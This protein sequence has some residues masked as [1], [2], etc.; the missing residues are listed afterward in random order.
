MRRVG[1]GVK[2]NGK[3]GDTEEGK[4]GGKGRQKCMRDQCFLDFDLKNI[5][6]NF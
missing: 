6:F 5:F 3:V 1:R 2:K 4:D